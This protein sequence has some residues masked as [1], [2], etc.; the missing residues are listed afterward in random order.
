MSA[1]SR[2]RRR[3]AAAPAPLALVLAALLAAAAPAPRALADEPPAASSPAAPARPVLEQV[4][5]L[6]EDGR[7]ADAIP[8]LE[9]HLADSLSAAE[10]AATLEWLGR[11][12]VRA[13]RIE[14]AVEAF[15]AMLDADPARRPDP[16]T[17]AGDELAAFARARREWL[18]RHPEAATAT[19]S[20]PAPPRRPF[21]RQGRWQI[22]ISGVAALA[23]VIIRHQA[24]SA[25]GDAALPNLP[26]HP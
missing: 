22:T 16:R 19:V 2:I 17:A 11:A 13:G 24:A 20:T 5:I 1:H 25:G 14:P 3:T 6:F 21:W 9:A 23:A 15:A 4:R 12:D 18:E 8:L 7:H 26:G 10:R